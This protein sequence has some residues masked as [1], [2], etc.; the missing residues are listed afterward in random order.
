MVYHLHELQRMMVEPWSELAAGSSRALRH[1][2]NP[3]RWLPNVRTLAA[4][5]AL[6]HRLTKRYDKPAWEISEVKA[7]GA[8]VSVVEEAVIDDPFYK[9]LHFVRRTQD[10][11]VAGH[12]AKAPR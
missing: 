2:S 5:Q 6:F 8:T 1:P 12:L 4:S 10:V 11:E 9:L 3:F 7:H